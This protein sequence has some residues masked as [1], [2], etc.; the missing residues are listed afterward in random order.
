RAAGGVTAQ[1]AQGDALRAGVRRA[2]VRT[3]ELLEAGDVL[4]RVLEAARAGRDDVLLVERDGVVGRRRRR[5]RQAA[6]GDNDHRRLVGGG[7]GILSQ[8]WSGRQR[9]GGKGQ[10][11]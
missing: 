1:R 11:S 8:C 3:A 10:V 2:A 7:G 4:Q 9:D 6:T 5:L